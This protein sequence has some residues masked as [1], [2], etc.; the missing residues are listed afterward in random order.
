[1]TNSF[2]PIYFRGMDPPKNSSS[3]PRKRISLLSLDGGGVRGLSSLRILERIMECI[4]PDDPPRPCDHFDMICGTSTGGLIAIMLGRLQMSVSECIVEY[5]KLSTSVF[6]KCQH[7]VNIWKR[8]LQGRFDHKALEAGDKDLL[9]RRGLDENELL[10]EPGGNPRCKTFICTM[11][12]ETSDIMIFPSY[13]SPTWGKPPLDS[14]RIWEAARA[15]SAATSF[16]DPLEINGRFYVDGATGANNPIYEL[17]AEA[18]SVYTLYDGWRLDDHLECLV[19][20]GTGAQSKKPFGSGLV[21]V[22]AAL[23]A[24]ATE[25]EAIA[26]QFQRQHVPLVGNS[27]L[28][29]FNVIDGL[30][31][32]GL[33]DADRLGEI[34]ASTDRYCATVSVKQ[35]VQA[36]ASRLR[37]KS[38]S[39]AATLAF[40][41][42][43]GDISMRKPYENSLDRMPEPDL[44]RFIHTK[45]FQQWVSGMESSIVCMTPVKASTIR[46]GAS[47]QSALA[48]DLSKYVKSRT[49]C[50]MLYVDCFWILQIPKQSR[51]ET[52]ASELR[53]EEMRAD[54]P[55]DD[56]SDIVMESLCRQLFQLCETREEVL[57][58]YCSSLPPEEAS[59][60]RTQMIAHG[61][62]RKQDVLPLL[63]R[64]HSPSSAPIII[65]IDRMNTL[66]DSSRT[67]L[68]SSLMALNAHGSFKSLLCGDESLLLTK[69][70]PLHLPIITVGIEIQECLA[71]L[72]FEE[73]DVRKSQVPPAAE[74]TTSWIWSHPVYQSFSSQ[75]SGILWIRGKPGSGKSV[76]ARAIQQR[77]RDHSHPKDGASVPMLIGDW[78][79]HR[80]RGGGFV[81]HESFV[82]SILC[83]F[84]QQDSKI[85]DFLQEAYRKMDPREEGAW[86]YDLIVNIFRRICQSSTPMLVVVDAVDEAENT[87][88]L[89]LIKSV[90]ASETIWSKARFIIISRPN[91]RIEREIEGEPTIV[92]ELANQKDIERIIN[93]GLASL[94][95]DIH[96]LDF[97]PSN[98]SQRPLRLPPR[99]QM[100][101]PRSRPFATMVDREKQAMRQIQQVLESKAQGCILWVKLMLDRMMQQVQIYHGSTLEDLHQLVTQVPEQ[102]AEYYKQLANEVTANKDD[103]TVSEIRMAL[104]WVCAAAE[105]GEVTLE[106]LWEALALL[107]WDFQSETLEAVW[108]RQL[109]VSSYNELWRKISTICGSFIEIFNPGL[110]ADESRIYHYG[111]ASIVQLIHQSVRDFL[112]DSDANDTGLRFSFDEARQMVRHRLKLYLGLAA[113][114]LYRMHRSGPQD[115]LLVVNWLDDQRLLHLAT[116]VGQTECKALLRIL[117]EMGLCSLR[118][119]DEDPERA[120]VTAIEALDHEHIWSQPLTELGRLTYHACTE[121][122]VTAMRNT[123]SLKWLPTDLWSL[124]AGEVIT[125]YILFRASRCQSP[126]VTT[127]LDLFGSGSQTKPASALRQETGRTVTAPNSTLMT[128]TTSFDTRYSNDKHKTPLYHKKEVAATDTPTIDDIGRQFD[129]DLVRWIRVLS[130]LDNSHTGSSAGPAG[131]AQTPSHARPTK[132]G[133]HDNP[134]ESNFENE[135]EVTRLLAKFHANNCATKGDTKKPVKK[136]VKL[137]L[138]PHSGGSKDPDEDR[139]ES[140]PWTVFISIDKGDIHIT[141]RVLYHMWS[142]FLDLVCGSK[143]SKFAAIKVDA[144]DRQGDGE[145]EGEYDLAAPVEDIEDTIIAALT[146]GSLHQ[147]KTQP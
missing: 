134:K 16:F 125:S 23:K 1:M 94:H 41:R 135:E 89:S 44:E 31:G 5:Q 117:W 60:F 137:T 34:E 28:F 63:G 124:A 121:G 35:Q 84:L 51:F 82:R 45:A 33:E 21:E 116:K 11:R 126:N 73:L 80:R 95:N 114:D 102:L 17:W 139:W 61:R 133:P 141:H 142:S 36:C 88:V 53:K 56:Q 24:I 50:V 12:Q 130:G 108:H 47:R 76:L 115:P 106:S 97:A 66:D 110:S 43:S 30:Q 147:L 75:D 46:E 85:F 62:P 104:M 128:N 74:G 109:I 40:E 37:E 6:T 4:N 22:A 118:E 10:R 144:V 72:S 86:A 39:T 8:E 79:Y 140:C 131:S 27:T 38:W 87:Q 101:Q 26:E 113:S 78:F 29:R 93:L 18:S 71:S 70:F 69:S 119:A 107:K 103:R 138:R 143:R 55:G 19:S 136:K 98:R 111:A 42:G 92:V 13:Y 65:S 20:I 83:H 123:F 90:F 59:H 7:R 15:T 2:I 32:I 14:V 49:D 100:R 122:S 81:R 64:L 77:L 96:S 127:G 54:H 146:L 105:Y 99:S 48:A 91:V 145:K 57:R 67:N 129:R 120:L 58:G 52:I 68:V 112:C 9:R 3:A 132:N 25:S